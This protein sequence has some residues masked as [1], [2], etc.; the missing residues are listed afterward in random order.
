[1]TNSKDSNSEQKVNWSELRGVVESDKTSV[2]LEKEM[3][4]KVD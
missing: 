2:E 1:M 3:W 4:K